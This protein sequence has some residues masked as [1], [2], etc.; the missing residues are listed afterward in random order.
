MEY[1]GEMW[2]YGPELCLAIAKNSE[3]SRMVREALEF[4][5]SRGTS[6]G[7]WFNR[8]HTWFRRQEDLDEYLRAFFEYVFGD[9]AE[10][11]YISDDDDIPD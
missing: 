10:P 8:T 4:V 2:R 11:I 7:E 6:R 5:I 9:R 3:Y 1:V